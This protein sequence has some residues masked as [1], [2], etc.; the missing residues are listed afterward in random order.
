MANLP[1]ISNVH[2]SINSEEKTLKRVTRGWLLWLSKWAVIMAT[3]GALWATFMLPAAGV[4][5]AGY[6][7]KDALAA[8][9]KYDLKLWRALKNTASDLFSNF[10][11]NKGSSS[12]STNVINNSNKLW[13]IDKID[14]NLTDME[15]HINKR[16]NI[17]TPPKT[18][19]DL[20]QQHIKEWL[21]TIKA[22][23][24]G[25]NSKWKFWD[26]N[27]LLWQVNK[28]DDPLQKTDFLDRID[29]MEGKIKEI[30][31]RMNGEKHKE[32]ISDTKTATENS[33][34][35]NT[36]SPTPEKKPDE[37]QNNIPDEEKSSTGVTSLLPGTLHHEEQPQE[38]EKEQHTTQTIK[39]NDDEQNTTNQP[40]SRNNV[41]KPQLQVNSTNKLPDSIDEENRPLQNFSVE[42]GK[43]LVIQLDKND[44]K[45]FDVNVTTYRRNKADHTYDA[46]KKTI[47]IHYNKDAHEQYDNKF[48]I[49]FSKQNGAGGKTE[50]SARDFQIHYT[51]P[52]TTIPTTAKHKNQSPTTKATT[53]ERAART[54]ANSK[55]NLKKNQSQQPNQTSINSSN[56]TQLSPSQESTTERA[57]R[58]LANSKLPIKK[59]NTQQQPS[60]ASVNSNN[61]QSSPSQGS[62]AERATRTLANSKSSLKKI[63]SINNNTNPIQININSNNKQS[64]T[65]AENKKGKESPNPKNTT[66]NTVITPKTEISNIELKQDTLVEKAGRSIVISGKSTPWAMVYMYIKPEQP[67]SKYQGIYTPIAVNAKWS[68]SMSRQGLVKGKY[69]VKLVAVNPKNINNKSKDKFLSV[70]IN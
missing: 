58:T 37:K 29:T 32:K 54:L 44:V 49:T 50:W 66:K 5:M 7:L 16:Y 30:E 15:A 53:A 11:N 31:E 45:D 2:N 13:T 34:T 69:K 4:I 25:W 23:L 65:S 10:W 46:H 62:T 42:K 57:T 43:D 68:F 64:A 3:A 28:L 67:N 20:V 70:T 40:G 63:T 12:T 21:A 8:G 22:K 27:G 9:F 19:W 48:A 17:T 14:G 59:T 24:R 38:E 39:N 55:L 47:T 51:D 52:Q 60:Q 18:P 26:K 41:P 61:T 33:Q 1:S 6:T 56:N 35:P 36:P